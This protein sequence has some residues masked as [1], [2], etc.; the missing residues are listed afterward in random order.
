LQCRTTGEEIALSETENEILK[1]L[2]RAGDAAVS[3]DTLYSK[4]WGHRTA[5][6]THT[7]QTHIYRLRRKIES[8]P[9]APTILVSETGGYRVLP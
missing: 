3:P 9:A 1:V 2:Y 8:D 4:V 7:L 6:N 5:L